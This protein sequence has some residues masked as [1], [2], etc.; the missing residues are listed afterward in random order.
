MTV[1]DEWTSVD[2]DTVD[3]H[4]PWSDTPALLF[5]SLVDWVR[6]WLIPTYRRSLELRENAW[7]PDWW[8]HA[9]VVVR[10]SALWRGFEQHRLEPGDAMSGWLRD[11]L[12]HHLPVI[13]DADRG[14][15][16]GCS[17]TKGHSS[18]PL[19]PLPLTTPPPA[20]ALYLT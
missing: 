10:L 4:D 17:S 9:E 8:R 1:I 2:P 5:P 15:L 16:K 3:A 18:R 20:L 14:P 7:C 6:D 13:M 11:H 19:P 12:D